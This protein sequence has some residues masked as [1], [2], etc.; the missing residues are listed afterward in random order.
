MSRKR[1]REQPSVDVQAV[2][3]Y[4]DLAN[5]SEEIRLKA[6]QALLSR[7][8]N[9]KSPS[10]GELDKILK[11]LFRGLCSGRKAARLGFSVALTEFLL[12]HAEP[13][14]SSDDGLAHLTM[15]EIV[16]VLEKQTHLGGS[17]AGQVDFTSTFSKC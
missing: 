12:Q 14:Q 16:D 6:A 3:I 4:E 8:S 9:E 15:V 11:R 13:T 17:V 2:E 5:E 1:R 10:H 7:I